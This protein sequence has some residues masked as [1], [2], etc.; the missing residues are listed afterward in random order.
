MSSAAL[1]NQFKAAR[2]A[3]TPLIAIQPDGTLQFIW[4][5]DLA[6]LTELGRASVIRASH[7]E[8]SLHG[9]FWTADLSPVGGPALGP[10]ALR[11]E[12]LEAEVAWLEQNHLH[13]H[14]SGAAA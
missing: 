6:P 11:H 12:A 4:R 13:V 1:L 14:E 2:R 7:V 9:D 5:D 3:A 10:F 8:P